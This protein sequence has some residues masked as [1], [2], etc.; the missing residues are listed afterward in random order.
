MSDLIRKAGDLY[1]RARNTFSPNKDLNALLEQ[2]R[3]FAASGRTGGRG[4]APGSLLTTPPVKPDTAGQAGELR[5]D[6]ATTRQEDLELLPGWIEQGERAGAA[7]ARNRVTEAD[8]VS[9]VNVNQFDQTSAIATRELGNR[10]TLSQQAALPMIDRAYKE[11]RINQNEAIAFLD[12]SR[13]TDA[14][15]E[16]ARIEAFNQANRFQ[17]ADALPLVGGLLSVLM[18]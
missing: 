11:G 17:I 12:R 16:R 15:L 10:L 1:G 9:R 3:Q 13:E 6:R 18:A 5:G 14:G 4:T 8:G 2:S 7:G